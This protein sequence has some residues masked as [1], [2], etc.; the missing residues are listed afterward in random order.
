MAIE[1]ARLY[2]ELQRKE[3]LRGELLRKVIAAQEEE[4]KRIARDLHDD[5]SQA[6]TAL[7][8][9]VDEALELRDPAE[10][11]QTLQ[12]MRTVSQRTLD[13]VHKLIFDLRPSLLD[14][15]GLVPALRWFAQSRLEPVHV[16]LLIEDTPAPRRLPAEIETVLFRVVQEAV[17]NI[18]RHALARN[19]RI[20]FTLAGDAAQVAIEDDGIGFDMVA[21]TLSPDSGRGLGLLGMQERVALLGGEFTI[22]SAP[23]YGTRIFITVPASASTGSAPFGPPPDCPSGRVAG[24]Q[25]VR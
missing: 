18:A 5:T 24:P 19:V 20:A 13:G 12:G 3:R 16:R 11:R 21:V 25:E 15:L 23:G 10:I 4:R 7:L 22:D 9:A 14:H 8:Y 1:N 2:A 17:T 6:L